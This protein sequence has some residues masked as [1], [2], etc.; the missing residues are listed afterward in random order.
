VGFTGARVLSLEFVARE[1]ADCLL[2]AR[3][4]EKD[5]GI[6]REEKSVPPVASLA[7]KLG[8]AGNLLGRGSN[9]G[10]KGFNSRIC[11][12]K[13]LRVG[14]ITWDENREYGVLRDGMMFY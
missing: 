1:L 5:R 12:V 4:I 6:L 8:R 9:R 10:A 11:T 14:P 2:G 13:R 3:A 7:G